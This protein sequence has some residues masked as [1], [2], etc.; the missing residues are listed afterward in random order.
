MYHVKYV[1]ARAILSVQFSRVKYIH[2]VVQK[3]SKIFSLPRWTSIPVNQQLPIAPLPH[4]STFW[5]NLNDFLYE[6]DYS[7]DLT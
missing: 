1:L 3:I 4:R 5:M 6:F 7:R 2:I